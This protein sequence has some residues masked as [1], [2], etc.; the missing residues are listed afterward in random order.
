MMR[1]TWRATWVKGAHLGKGGQGLTYMTRQNR[2]DS[3]DEYVLK[4]LVRQDDRERRARMHQE[5]ANLKRLDHPNVSKY[6]DSNFERYHED[7]ELYLVTE[8]IPGPNLA[9]FA[10]TQPLDASHAAEVLEVLLITLD[11]C[12]AKGVVH[13]DIKPE[14]IILRNGNRNDPVLLD[15]GLSFNEETQPT[16]FETPLDQHMGNRFIVL[17]EYGVADDNKRDPRSDI[18]QCVGILFFL[19]T[20]FQPGN[21][22]DT[23]NQK[24]HTRPGAAQKLRSLPEPFANRLNRIFNIGFN[25]EFQ[26]RWQSIPSLLGEIKQLRDPTP[27]PRPSL[28]ALIQQANQQLLQTPQLRI[29][30]RVEKLRR[31]IHGV[32]AKTG[33]RLNTGLRDVLQD[34]SQHLFPGNPSVKA[35]IGWDLHFR[36]NARPAIVYGFCA[37]LLDGSSELSIHGLNEHGPTPALARFGIFDDEALNLTQSAAE[38]FIANEVIPR[39]TR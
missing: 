3:K 32:F 1:E 26:R 23:R 34:A 9:D 19:T 12:H 31:E 21:I 11:H 35:V 36:H 2:P 38:D 39:L 28:D 16:S 8:F 17:P 33:D 24:P 30:E 27:P 18:A 25:H 7:E 20:G 14:N 5:V 4:L 37:V 29:Q 15:F 13:R 10:T 22:I 6:I